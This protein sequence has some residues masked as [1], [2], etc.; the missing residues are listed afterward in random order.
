MWHA[1]VHA[2]EGNITE[3]NDPN[4]GPNGGGTLG[5]NPKGE[6]WGWYIDAN[7]AFHGYLRS[8]DGTFTEVDAPGAGTGAYQGT[9]SCWSNICAG[10]ITPDGKVT[11]WYAD[12][13]NV[14]H[15]FVRTS[16]GKFKTFDA[17]GAGTGAWQ[18]TLPVA[19]NPEGMIAGYYTDT[20]GVV[21][22]FV[23]SPDQDQR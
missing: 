23:R 19:I 17:P 6:I 3:F 16:L 20:K 10:G 14:F 2:P 12:S 1:Y 4:V 9:T 5:I 13:N 15:G 21:H 8:P 18:G 7:N 22:G 11:G